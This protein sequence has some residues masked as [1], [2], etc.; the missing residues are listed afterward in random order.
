MIVRVT[1]S[2]VF[3]SLTDSGHFGP[4]LSPGT[5]GWPGSGFTYPGVVGS[6]GISL[7]I[8]LNVT[9]YSW[10]VDASAS[11]TFSASVDG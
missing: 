10:F 11:N 2:V 3:R 8:G 9:V 1:D 4:L 5:T 6:V 7:I